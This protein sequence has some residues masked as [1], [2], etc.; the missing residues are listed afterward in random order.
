[1]IIRYELNIRPESRERIEAK[2]FAISKDVDVIALKIVRK[3]K[4]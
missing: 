3:E 2:L 1:M 4:K